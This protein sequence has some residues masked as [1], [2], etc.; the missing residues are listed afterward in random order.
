VRPLAVKLK[1]WEDLVAHPN[2]LEL[3]VELE[4]QQRSLSAIKADTATQAGVDGGVPASILDE[5]I[6]Q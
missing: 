2:S 5:W 1:A 6:N 3:M 4:E